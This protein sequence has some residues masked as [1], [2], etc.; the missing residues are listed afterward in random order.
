[1]NPEG[2]YDLSLSLY[3]AAS[4]RDPDIVTITEE[5]GDQPS[6]NTGADL[7]T[8]YSIFLLHKHRTRC[9]FS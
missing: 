4:G 2:L 8:F 7:G 6:W 5:W 9:L 1:M 3:P